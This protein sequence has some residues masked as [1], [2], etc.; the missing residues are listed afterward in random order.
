[1]KALIRRCTSLGM[2]PCSLRGAWLAALRAKFRMRPMTALTNGHLDGGCIN[3][4]M[5]GSPPC[6][7]TAFWATSH[8]GCREVKCLN[9]QK[10][11]I[12]ITFTLKVK[13]RGQ[14]T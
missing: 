7:L 10:R 1:M 9:V 3:R 11:P 12:S 6:S 14:L 2:A 4:T 13:L 5:V 8:S